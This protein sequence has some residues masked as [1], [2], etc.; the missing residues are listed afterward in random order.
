VSQEKRVEPW[1]RRLGE[2]HHGRHVV[3]PVRDQVDVEA[4]GS[5]SIFC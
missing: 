2:R 5:L 3:H 4:L 1:V